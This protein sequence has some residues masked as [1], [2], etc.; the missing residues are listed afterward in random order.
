MYSLGNLIVDL[1]TSSVFLLIIAHIQF[2]LKF[3]NILYTYRDK[4]YQCD[5]HGGAPHLQQQLHT[6]MELW[7]QCLLTRM[8]TSC[9]PFSALFISHY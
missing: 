4:L 1:Y 6:A 7:L 2:L 8:I 5:I 9:E 3:M